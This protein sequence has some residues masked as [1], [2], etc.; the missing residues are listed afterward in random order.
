[1]NPLDCTA[2]FASV[3]KLTRADQAR[4]AVG[5]TLRKYRRAAGMTQVAMAK[6]LKVGQAQIS[7]IERGE[8]NLR[9]DQLFRWAVAVGQ[10]PSTMLSEAEWAGWTLTDEQATEADL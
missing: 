6:H 8:S 4:P 5:A 7:K 10:P 1:M 2:R 9:V 3:V